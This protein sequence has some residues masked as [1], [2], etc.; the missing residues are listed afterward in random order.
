VSGAITSQ[1]R[2]KVPLARSAYKEAA[3]PIVPIVPVS[4]R[5]EQPAGV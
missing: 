5:G 1:S 2:I 3:L 4:R